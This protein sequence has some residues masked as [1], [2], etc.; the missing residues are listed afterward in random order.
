MILDKSECKNLDVHDAPCNDETA[1]F[2]EEWKSGELSRRDSG[3]SYQ[4]S[5]GRIHW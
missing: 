4:W 5:G 3:T 2:L 1:V